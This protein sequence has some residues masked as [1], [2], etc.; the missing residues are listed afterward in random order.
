MIADS[1]TNS[2][3][4]YSYTM[5]T[6]TEHYGQPHQLALRRIAELME[7]PN[8]RTNDTGAF[9]KFALQMRALVGMLDQL[10]IVATSSCSV[11]H[12]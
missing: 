7:A 9:K 3:Q 5:A 10:M 1:Y 8:I 6:L 12:M 11:G 2:R 4:P